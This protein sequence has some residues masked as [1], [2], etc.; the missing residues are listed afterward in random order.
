M[1][2]TWHEHEHIEKYF[3]SDLLMTLPKSNIGIA[4]AILAAFYVIT[5]YSWS[6]LL[7]YIFQGCIPGMVWKM[8]KISCYLNTTWHKKRAKMYEILDLYLLLNF[9]TPSPPPP[10]PPPPPQHTHTNSSKYIFRPQRAFLMWKH[11]ISFIQLVWQISSI[12]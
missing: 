5:S 1:R 8:G 9:N 4:T 6:T 11:Y 7:L 2:Y 10:P 12:C 3:H